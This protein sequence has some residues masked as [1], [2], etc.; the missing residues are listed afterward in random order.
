MMLGKRLLVRKIVA[1]DS[2][3]EHAVLSL[4]YS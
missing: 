3:A 4:D 2:M 1:L